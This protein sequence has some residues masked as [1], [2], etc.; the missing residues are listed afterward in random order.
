[1]RSQCKLSILLILV[2]CFNNS[3]GQENLLKEGQ[4]FTSTNI[5]LSANKNI[6][7]SYVDQMG[8]L[9]F[10]SHA[11]T[12]RYDG[13]QI[14]EINTNSGI[15]PF[16]RNVDLILEDDKEN[17]YFIYK[18]Y[19]EFGLMESGQLKI[20][21]IQVPENNKIYSAHIF[22]NQLLLLVK[23][24]EEYKVLLY[25]ENNFVNIYTHSKA[26]NN[27]SAEMLVDQQNIFL[28][29]NNHLVI[30]AKEDKTIR[31]FTVASK[32]RKF[33]DSKQVLLKADNNNIIFTSPYS[34]KIF[35]LGKKDNYNNVIELDLG[36]RDDDIISGIWKDKDDRIIISWKDIKGFTERI[37]QIDNIHQPLITELEIADRT[38][39]SISGHDFNK[40]LIIGSYYGLKVINKYQPQF[41]KHLNI[42][43][44]EGNYL[45]SGKSMRGFAFNNDQLFAA[46]EISNLYQF[47]EDIEAFLP[48]YLHRG[49]D[50]LSLRCINSILNLEEELWF[51]SCTKND[52]NYLIQY[53]TGNNNYNLYN[54]PGRIQHMAFDEGKHGIYLLTSRANESSKLIYFNILTKA[55]S[56]IPLDS[57]LDDNIKFTFISL[58]KNHALIGS[59][60]GLFII[61]LDSHAISDDLD[62]L[63]E[64]FRNKHIN[65]ISVEEE[66]IIIGTMENG[67]FFYHILTAEII[68]ISRLTGLSSNAICGVIP[69]Y[70]GN[71]WVSTYNG[72]YVIDQQKNVSYSFFESDGINQNEFNRF[73][74]LGRKDKI[75]FGG[76]NGILEI[77][78]DKFIGKDTN[79]PSY[80]ISSIS[81]YDEK[82]KGQLS[83][84]FNGPVDKIILQPYQENLSIKFK[85]LNSIKTLQP[86]RVRIKNKE[87]KWHN[88]GED[89]TFQFPDF[90]G[91]RYSLEVEQKI[92]GSD[93][94]K[95]ETISIPVI[96]EMYFYET[97]WFK[98]LIIFSILSALYLYFRKSIQQV[99]EMENMRG[100]IA[101][102]LHDSL[103]SLL[104][105]MASK[106]EVALQR[107]PDNQN[108]NHFIKESNNALEIMRDAIWSINPD[109]DTLRNLVDRMKDFAFNMLNHKDIP[110]EYQIDI[111]KDSKIKP[112]WRREFY[113]IFKEAITN[114]LKHA[115]PSVVRIQLTQDKKGI[116]MIINNDGITSSKSFT[117]NNHN[118]LSMGLK[119]MTKRAE[120]LNGGMTHQVLDNNEFQIEI[121]A[122]L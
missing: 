5:E 66:D 9:W 105:G 75:Y 10:S 41:T 48:L 77:D 15:A 90:G 85:P 16:D 68:Q 45:E 121:T 102:D 40:E 42:Y 54:A 36:S 1:M 50:T 96:M 99:K 87:Y 116:S 109:N 97:I 63:E 118:G 69:D 44:E 31:E 122:N 12:Y 32:Q 18:N 80:L 14:I 7:Y 72:L 71:Y 38:L 119:T 91:G 13:S 113:L 112:I 86:I 120:N 67:L 70:K 58:H 37:I 79:A 25:R 29:F 19:D 114:I 22:N 33:L 106:A 98:I 35:S 65:F 104:T 117:S 28:L 21:E 62:N 11:M 20:A 34:G 74:Y 53:H 23:E 47:N 3:I 30:V 61:P 52:N 108:Y 6:K 4:D 111:D 43:E 51:S 73:S 84:H 83:R 39:T 92:Q 89:F 2:L 64:E 88:L 27:L 101:S 82:Q 94:Q 55:F 110:V 8:Y 60:N 76:I 100:Q 57:E 103:G 115:E 78:L 95:V 81:Y 49:N 26:E 107:N 46:R 17:K 56:E 93:W 59:Y 24:G